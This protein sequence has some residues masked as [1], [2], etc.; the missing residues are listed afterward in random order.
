MDCLTFRRQM[1]EDP[2]RSDADLAAHEA[3]CAPCAGFAHSLRDHEAK[4]SDILNIAPPP[5]LTERIQLAVSFGPAPRRVGHWLGIAAAGLVAIAAGTLTWLNY[6]GKPYEQLSLERSVL[7]HVADETRHLY[8]PGPAEVPHVDKVFGRF[9]AKVNEQM[10][11]QV[12]FAG[13]CMM[14]RNRGVHLVLR[15]EMGP[16]TVFFMPGEMAH[17]PMSLSSERFAGVIEPTQWGSIAVVGEPGESLQPVLQRVRH[18]VRWPAEQV[19]LAYLPDNS[20]RV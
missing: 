17:K 4:L 8:D 7:H 11:G 1:L 13:I 20:R 16:V 9:G 2:S 12:N 19:S 15:G 3:G 5:E 6:Y 18:A 14:R 10:L